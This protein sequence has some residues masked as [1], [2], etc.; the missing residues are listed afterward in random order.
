MK[1]IVKSYVVIIVVVLISAVY[2]TVSMTIF[3]RS[4]NNLIDD[5]TSMYIDENV[6]AMAAI[7]QTKLEDQ[8]VMLESQV[9]YFSDID[10]ADYNAMRD[11][12]MS[13]K[14]I[15]AFKNI[16]VANTTGATI[17]YNGKSSGNIMLTDY[18]KEAMQ[19]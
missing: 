2:L 5:T 3:S 4:T 9:R 7:F 14:G 11:I 12:I 18:F 8:L 1:K 19:G 13:T 16:G 15:G 10:L 17:N 6:N